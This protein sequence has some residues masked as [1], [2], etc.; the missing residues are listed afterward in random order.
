MAHVR[1]GAVQQALKLQTIGV[2]VRDHIAHLAD[3]CREYK[4]ANKVADDGENVSVDASAKPN[5]RRVYPRKVEQ[6]EEEENRRK[7]AS[8]CGRL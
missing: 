5:Q 1:F 4:Y 2:S 6:E 8:K 7:R 3:D